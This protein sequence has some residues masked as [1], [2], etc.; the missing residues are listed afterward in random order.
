MMYEALESCKSAGKRA[1]L[2]T[3]AYLG[4]PECTWK[5]DLPL[6]ILYLRLMFA[7]VSS[8]PLYSVTCLHFPAKLSA[9]F[10]TKEH[11]QH[12]GNRNSKVV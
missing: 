4:K 11:K 5:F 6:G 12:H 9:Y 8:T 1:P 10:N 3:Q 7:V 2:A